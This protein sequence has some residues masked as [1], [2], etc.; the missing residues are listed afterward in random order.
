[1]LTLNSNLVYDENMKDKMKVQ[2]TEKSWYLLTNIIPLLLS[3]RNF[4]NF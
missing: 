4:K 3:I 2:Y 1:M